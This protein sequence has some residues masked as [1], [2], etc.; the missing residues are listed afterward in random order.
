[1]DLVM[2]FMINGPISVWD[3]VDRGE[4]IYGCVGIVNEV[5][6]KGICRPKDRQK[7]LICQL[8]PI[9]GVFLNPT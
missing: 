9:E 8:P 7:S 4:M 1:M 5:C 6:K 2:R 3:G